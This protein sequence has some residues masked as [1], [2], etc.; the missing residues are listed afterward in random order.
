MKCTACG[1]KVMKKK[2][3]VAMAGTGLGEFDGYRCGKC[4]EEW[5]DEKTVDRIQEIA[6]KKGVWGTEVRSKISYS[7][8]SLIVRIPKKI[9]ELLGLRKGTEVSLRP[10][11][12]KLVVE[13]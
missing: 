5:F 2:I 8:N 1:G 3:E 10:E 7:G 6:R 13:V 12:R 4:G 11:G 9:S